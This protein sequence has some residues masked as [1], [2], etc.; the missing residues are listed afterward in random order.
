[1]VVNFVGPHSPF[2]PPKEYS[3]KYRDR[4]MPDAI[5]RVTKGKPQWILDRD[6]GLSPQEVTEAQRQ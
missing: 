4:T 1:M 2:D 5:P 3:N 6:L